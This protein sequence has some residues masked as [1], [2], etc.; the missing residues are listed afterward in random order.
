MGNDHCRAFT[1][2][3]AA[4][5]VHIQGCLDEHKWYMSEAAGHDVGREAASR[6]FVERHLDRVAR[7][8]RAA[9]CFTACE[10]RNSCPVIRLLKTPS[11][12]EAQTG[13]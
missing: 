10:Q 13:S 3:M 5:R 6:D 1:Q 8:F 11:A 12:P 2:F 7:E 9:F 4:Q